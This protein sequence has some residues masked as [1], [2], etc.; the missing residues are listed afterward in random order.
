MTDSPDLSGRARAITLDLVSWPSVTGTP[1]EADF[2]PRLASL[3]R[4]LPHLRD[5][6]DHVIVE[7]LPADALGRANVFAF[8]PGRGRRLV[9]LCGHFDVVPVDD[10][11]PLKPLAGLSE[12]LRAAMIE[13]LTETGVS[14]LA[15]EDLRS[16]AFLPGRGV[17]DMKSGLAAGI[18]VLE[19][20]A[21]L[22]EHQREGSLLLVATPDEEDRSAGMRAAAATLPG[23]LSRFDRDAVL[24]I[25]LDALC[26]NADGA[27]GR[28][29]ALGCIGKLLL[30]ALVVGKEAHACY[31]LDGVNASYLAAE[32]VVEL[33]LNPELGEETGAELASPP[34]ALGSR[35]LKDIYNVTT[36]GRVW[37]TWNVLTQKRSA[38][39]VLAIARAAARR[40]AERARERLAQRA[41]ALFNPVELTE[42]WDRIAVLGFE[43]VFDAALRNG[44]DAFRQ[45]FDTTA[46][47]LAQR[48]EMD[49]PTRCRILTGMAWDASGLEAPAIVLGFASLPYPAVQPLTKAAPHLD[50]LLRS[51]AERVGRAHG[52]TIGTVDYMPVIVDMSFLGE[53]DGE[54]L[55][56][57]AAA[58]P[59]WNSSIRWSLD[60]PPTPGLP[61]IN[62]G[63]WGRDYHHWLERTHE[64]YTFEVLPDLVWTVAM[65]VLKGP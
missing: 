43:D 10:Y 30:S 57:T 4:G 18:A 34:T 62:I 28:V 47:A 17:L 63:P 14:S 40:A 33:E 1:D 53:V 22:P 36:P 19:A 49:L 56:R 8:V 39:D 25:N 41:A 26:D 7:P 45:A 6:P 5:V 51:A 55:A 44:G 65:D 38:G 46:L 23:L 50:V 52:T 12:Q 64:T 61:V 20:F 2:A 42:R 54:D 29:V 3:L 27:G 59:I 13:R 48:H 60:K 24:A 11:G 16:G 58:T 9:V 15:L 32:L 35:D 31:P 21:A 37:S